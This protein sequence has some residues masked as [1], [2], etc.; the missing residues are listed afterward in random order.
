MQTT[1]S[2]TDEQLAHYHEHG[3]VVVN[4]VFPIDELQQMNRELDAIIKACERGEIQNRK[5]AAGWLMALGLLTESTRD[6]CED[7]R[8]LN[9][10]DRI[11]YPG[12]A[13]YSAKLVS[14]EPRDETICHWHQDDAYYTQNSDS[15]CRMS[16]WVPL[17]DTTKEQGCL[18]LVPGSHRQGLQPYSK[19]QT[20]TCALAMD[21]DVDM[22]KRIYL[23][24]KAGSMVLF[25]A[26]LW[27]ASDGNTTENRRRAF[28]V[29]YQE[30]TAKAG[31]GQ[32]WKILRDA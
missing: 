28:I 16:I 7:E 32:Q 22:S 11:V 26:L 12:I 29:S 30:A 23:P 15:A 13:I 2:L 4:D 17:Q 10:I 31:N 27:H 20:G 3:Y 9:L 14:K 21:I 24:A 6:F 1:R 5:P 25:S 18:Q 8:I 19:R